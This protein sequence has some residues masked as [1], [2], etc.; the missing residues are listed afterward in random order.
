MATKGCF[1]LVTLVRNEVDI[2]GNNM[3]QNL[4]KQ[5]L[6]SLPKDER[7]HILNQWYIR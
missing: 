1:V 6:C 3:Q 7:K 5:I 4:G 2:K